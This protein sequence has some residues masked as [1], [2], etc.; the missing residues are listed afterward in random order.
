MLQRPNTSL[1]PTAL[2]WLPDTS[3]CLMT[4]WY[5]TTIFHLV[6]LMQSFWFEPLPHP[7]SHVHTRSIPPPDYIIS[8][9]E[10]PIHLPVIV[11]LTPFY[12]PS[13]WSV[14]VSLKSSAFLHLHCCPRIQT[15]VISHLDCGKC[16][17]T[18]QC[19]HSWLLTC[20]FPTE[21]PEGPL[22]AVTQTTPFLRRGVG[23]PFILWKTAMLF[24]SGDKITIVHIFY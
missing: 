15:L 10:T 2:P 5:P 19:F 8:W 20:T 6:H 1:Q 24:M 14:N 7:A 22:H 11:F 23:V 13:C 16:P 12:H 4:I 9:N 18:S 3:V 21:Q 17:L